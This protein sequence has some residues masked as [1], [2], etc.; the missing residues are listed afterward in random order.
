MRST[1]TSFEYKFYSYIRILFVFIAVQLFIFSFIFLRQHIF[2]ADILEHL[3]KLLNQPTSTLLRE[4]LA[5]LRA[6][7]LDD[8]V[9]VEYGRAHD[10]ARVIASDTLCVITN[11]LEKFKKDSGVI[12]DIMLTLSALLVRTE[13]CKKVEDAGGIQIIHEAMNDFKDN[14]KIVKQC[15]KVLKALAGND[16]CKVHIIQ[17][18]IAPD[19][20]LVMGQ[21]KKAAQTAAFGLACIAAL[22]LRSPDNSKA[23]FQAGAPDVIVEV[24]SLHADNETVQVNF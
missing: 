3:K 11:L 15:L 18:G 12:N 16:E 17:R 6:L 13:F 7:V 20:V 22:S 24:M 10:H 4:V 23:L 2:D 9:R 21:H 14:D 8:D 5:V 1:Q 19:I